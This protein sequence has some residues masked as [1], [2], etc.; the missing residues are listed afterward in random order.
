[1]NRLSGSI[2]KIGGGVD[3][4]FAIVVLAS[5]FATFS[6]FQET[7]TV[8]LVLMIVLGMA[9]L[10]IGIYGYGFCARLEWFPADLAYFV[11]QSILGGVIVY[12]GRGAGFNALVLLPLA[13][14]AVVLLPQRW[15]YAVNI[16]VLVTYIFTVH[17]FSGSWSV[18]WGGLPTFLAGI[19][20]IV[21]FTQ[22]AVSEDKARSEVQR[23]VSELTDANQ[24]LREYVTQVE[25]LAI[26]KERNR[27]ARE[28]HDGLGHYLTTIH[29]QIQASRAIL[30]TEPK[31]VDLMLEKA[32]NLSQEALR[33][34]RQSVASLRNEDGE[35][36]LLEE[37]IARLLQSAELNNTQ[38]DFS[39]LGKVRKLSPQVELT[40]FRA[41]QEGINNTCKHAHASNLWVSL[42]YRN[43]KNIRLTIR[44]NGV[45]AQ[46]IEG[47]FGL[48]GLQERVHLLGGS[49]SIKTEIE[50]GFGFEM[51]VPG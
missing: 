36:L 37:K 26:T 28:I 31:R 8:K 46:S 9:Y 17:L 6:A 42:D 32:Q 44:D 48:M 51:V 7:N 47:G 33:D 40:I 5:Y 39:T 25:E 30:P 15:A 10:S 18:V 1:M 45:G 35:A 3:L 24:R 20:F 22:M 29:M 19:I 16:M 49:M 21:V 4:A 14:Q 50:Q 27:L 43:A 2:M 12:I 38:T 41:V 34:V 13:G 23:L 11:I